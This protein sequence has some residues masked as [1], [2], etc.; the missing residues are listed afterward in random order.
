MVGW[1]ALGVVRIRGHRVKAAR[2]A[3]S[4]TAGTWWRERV[5][6][7]VAVGGRVACGWQRVGS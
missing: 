7:D 6:R 5:S 4:E 2:V 3:G 1:L